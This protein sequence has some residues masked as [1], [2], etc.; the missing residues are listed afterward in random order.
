MAVPMPNTSSS[1]GAG[2][3][4]RTLLVASSAT[5]GR[6]SSDDVAATTL[7]PPADRLEDLSGRPRSLPVAGV[8]GA[9]AL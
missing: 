5:D 6:A 4:A 2:L 9:V 3:M 7:R 8:G 1:A